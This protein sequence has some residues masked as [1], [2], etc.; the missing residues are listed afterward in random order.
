MGTVAL[1]DAG[2]DVLH[3]P[4]KTGG[5]AFGGVQG[6]QLL[7]PGRDAG[8]A[9]AEGLGVAAAQAGKGFVQAVVKVFPLVIPQGDA[10]A[11][12]GVNPGG[13]RVGGPGGRRRGYSPAYR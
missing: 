10:E 2:G 6:P 7:V 8:I 9:E 3:P 5:P 4:E 12:A 11:G 13:A 1:P